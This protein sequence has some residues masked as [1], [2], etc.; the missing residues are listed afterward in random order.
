MTTERQAPLVPPEVDL[1]GY[2]F[3]PMFGDRLRASDTNGTANDAEF[4]AAVNLWWSS[5][6]QIPAASLPDDDKVLCKLADLG[7]DLKA[8]RKVK[9]VAMANFVL[10]SDGRY[11]HTFLAGEAL[12]AWDARVKAREKARI[13]N[14]KRW[15]KRPPDD[16]GGGKVVDNHPPGDPTATNRR[17]PEESHSDT[18]RSPEE[19]SGGRKGQDRTGQESTNRFPGGD[20]S[21]A[22]H[23]PPPAGEDLP[24]D[25]AVL[26]RIVVE[27]Q[28]AKMLEATPENPM[29]LRWARRGATPAQVTAALAEARRPGCKPAPE[30]LPAAYV[31]AILAKVVKADRAARAAVEARVQ[32]TAKATA[33]IKA[34]RTTAVPPP[35]ELVEQQ[36]RKAAADA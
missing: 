9:A 11:Y 24:P 21:G 28:R 1:S 6:K 22:S 29:I 15:G 17:S 16:P 3:M 14:E 34:A 27:C 23:G 5:W 26:A 25:P 35:A 10:C 8:W 32:A 18:E 31:E 30:D 36:R 7:R 20:N 2:E 12:K 4:R 13:A 19:S 33:E